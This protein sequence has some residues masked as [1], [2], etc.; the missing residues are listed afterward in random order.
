MAE[1]SCS[2]T[3][4]KPYMT[5]DNQTRDFLQNDPDIFSSTITHSISMDVIVIIISFLIT[6]PNLL[7]I[8]GVVKTNTSMTTSKKLTIYHASINILSGLVS[9][10]YFVFSAHL[11]LPCYHVFI[12]N[13]IGFVSTVLGTEIVLTM[14]VLRYVAIVKP[15]NKAIHSGKLISLLMVIQLLIALTSGIFNVTVNIFSVIL[16]PLQCL[17]SG[18]LIIVFIVL[19]ILG[20]AYSMLY[21]KRQKSKKLST[22][23]CHHRETAPRSLKSQQENN[24]SS[25]R[26]KRAIWRLLQTSIVIGLCFLPS[27]ICYVYVGKLLLTE[28]FTAR[29]LLN[30]FDVADLCFIPCL[31]SP[32]ICPCICLAWDRRTQRYYRSVL[33]RY[34]TI[35]CSKMVN[36]NS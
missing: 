2:I 8:W 15:F 24:I 4:W 32:M 17:Y 28:L 21:I 13:A 9:L 29:Q 25:K 26:Y 36:I 5:D 18:S 31:I 20:N 16:Y 11:G 19:S 33:T 35:R 22:H 30:I 1:T 7:L 10:P 34:L 3:Y 23:C 27:A 6:V 12:A 14:T